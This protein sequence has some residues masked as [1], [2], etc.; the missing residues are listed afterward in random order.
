MSAT[1]LESEAATKAAAAPR[2]LSAL[3]FCGT[4]GDDVCTCA[5]RCERCLAFFA[6]CHCPGHCV[7]CDA[8]L[9]HGET[10]CDGCADEEEDL[11][12][13]EHDWECD[14]DESYEN[15]FEP[16]WADPEHA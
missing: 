1:R 8:E 13:T 10:L 5:E 7:G 4:C 12:R 2:I 11:A 16:D 3:G 9:E 6:Q 14:R 15:E